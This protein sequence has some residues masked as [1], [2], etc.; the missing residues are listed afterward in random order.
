MPHMLVNSYKK[1]QILVILP[2]NSSPSTPPSEDLLKDAALQQC[3]G[4]GGHRA[5]DG[6][7]LQNSKGETSP[8]WR[9]YGGFLKWWYPTTMGFPTWSF[10]DV[11]GV[12]PY[13]FNDHCCLLEMDGLKEL[14]WWFFLVDWLIAKFLVAVA[15]NSA[16][17]TTSLRNERVK[18]HC[19]ATTDR[20]LS[21]KSWYFQA[22]SIS[23]CR[24]AHLRR[25]DWKYFSTVGTC[26]TIHGWEGLLTIGKL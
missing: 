24:Y 18:T 11:L 21:R 3:G 1:S 7:G 25:C 15:N 8:E 6:I 4:S 17:L 23:L 5:G 10:W 14:D 19:P 22:N 2:H 16:I 26:C 20:S 13:D 12:H 9:I